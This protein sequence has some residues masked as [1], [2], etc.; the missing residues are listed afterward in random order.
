MIERN[1]D[2]RDLF[3]LDLANNHQGDVAHG[4]RVIREHAAAVT[5]AGV[6]AAIK[7]Q[8]RDLPGFVHPDDRKNSTNKHVPRFLSTRLP[9][10]AYEEMLEEVR[11]QGLLSMCTP[12]DE[13]SVDHIERMGF[14]IIKVA[15]C[16]AADWPL[17]ERVAASGL[18]VIASTGGLGTH[19]VD[20]LQSFLTHRA[21]DFALMHCVSIYPTP[22]EACNLGNIAAFKE[23]YRDIVIGWSTHETPADTVHVGLAQALGAEMFER[24]IGVETDEIKLNAYSAT[25]DQTRAWLAAWK[26][27]RT[28]I[29]AHEREPARPEEAEAIQGL[30]R[31][32]FAKAPIEK[33]QKIAR[34]DVYFAFPRRD[35]Q[36]ASGG[37]VEGMIAEAPIAKDAPLM[38]EAVTV[39]E[40]G[41]EI[42]LKRAVHEV[43]AMLTKARV[44]LSHDFTTEYSHHYGVERFNEVGAVLIT[45]VNREY[46][47]KILVQL[48]GQSH[49][50]HY[51]KLKE[52]TFVVVYGDLNIELDGQLRTLVPG[53]TL[54][55]RPGIWH[56]F[57]TEGG[58]IF[59]EISTTAHRGDSVY[60]DP[61][62]NRLEHSERKTVVDHWGRFQLNEA[63]RGR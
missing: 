41:R 46:A 42:I 6:R 25:P 4:R 58:C 40:R 50:L 18:P 16:S 27:A 34:E 2:F 43:K 38:P 60:R 1:F 21:C 57:W 39:P 31:G 52:E 17:L 56:R 11:T 14:D 7:F 51:H 49:P 47:K 35:G 54:T 24:H 62:I 55:V 13:S 33:G 9:W 63:L 45:V 20:A 36:I 28:I 3:V 29:G 37:W 12:F 44:P 5:E 61:A 22:D 30:Q 32:I 26:R 23:R 8:F 19:E 15:S 59:E 10:E 48:P 53:D